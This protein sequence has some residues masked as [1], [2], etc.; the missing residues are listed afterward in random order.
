[1]QSPAGDLSILSHLQ[2]DQQKLTERYI[3]TSERAEA[4]ASILASS[5]RVLALVVLAYA[6]WLVIA[7]PGNCPYCNENLDAYRTPLIPQ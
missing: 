6:S 2:P 1:M 4:L 3:M 5:V 7:Q